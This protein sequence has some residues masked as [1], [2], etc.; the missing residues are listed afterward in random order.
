MNTYFGSEGVIFFDFTVHRGIRSDDVLK[1]RLYV[2]HNNQVCEHVYWWREHRCVWM[3][4]FVIQKRTRRRNQVSL[5]NL[6][7]FKLKK[8][9]YLHNRDLPPTM[10]YG[11]LSLDAIDPNM[12]N[13]MSEETF[14][15]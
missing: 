5:R 14:M 4:F 9:N 3:N 13:R 8:S 15:T 7:R 1:I 6:Q 10:L 2:F 11:Q 12:S